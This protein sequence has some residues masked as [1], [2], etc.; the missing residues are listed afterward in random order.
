MFHLF[1]KVIPVTFRRVDIL[2]LRGFVATDQKQDYRSAIF[3]KI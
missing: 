3:A 2:G 1:P